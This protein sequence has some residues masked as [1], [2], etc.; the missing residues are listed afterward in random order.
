MAYYAGP[1]RNYQENLLKTLDENGSAD[2]ITV[3]CYAFAFPLPDSLGNIVPKIRP[4]PTY[5]EIYS[6]EMSIDGQ[7]DSPKQSLR[8]VF[9]QLKKLKAKHP[10]IKV[11]LSIGGWG[12]STYFSDLALTPEA[13][14]KFV[15]TCIDLYI[16]GNLPLEDGA[17]GIGSAKGV[18]DG[19]DI[20]WEFP[21]SGGPEG[22]HYNPNDRENMSA[23]FALFRKK[24]DVIDPNLLLTAAISGRVW[25][26]WKYNFDEDKKNLD[27]FNVM[28]YDF[29]GFGDSVT[30]HNTN[31]LSSPDDPDPYKE[32]YDHAIKYLIDSAGVSSSKI[33]PG[34]SFYARIWRNIDSTNYGLYQ[35]VDYSSGKDIIGYSHFENFSDKILNNKS[36]W[37]NL[38]MAPWLYDPEDKSF[39]SFDDTRSIALKRQ[40]VD[41]YNLRGLMFWAVNGDDSSGTLINTI[42][43]KNMP[44]YNSFAP[45]ANNS[46]P[47]I[48]I[49]EPGDLSNIKEGSNIRI[50]TSAEDKDG[51][52]VKVEFFVDGNS[53]G[54]NTIAPF[55]WV[56]FNANSGKHQVKAVAFDN[57]GGK[58]SSSPV[59]INII[60]K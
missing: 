39:W 50:V 36:H 60:K 11:E 18:F 47:E 23:L 15:D 41:A 52:I 9:N 33:I 53:I 4:Y 26:F 58:S 42:Y 27:W 51:R 56:W 45:K 57:N 49:I 2:K 16:K 3:I 19:F 1:H 54:Y 38:A 44:D 31:L 30:G 7:A 55:D 21:V 12:G 34:A 28:T 24:M 14:E 13:R 17:G 6:S 29:H 25:E 40:Y 37:D 22:T 32:S 43:N 48:K 5:Q 46:L 8:G 59:E 10:N 20:D 35:P